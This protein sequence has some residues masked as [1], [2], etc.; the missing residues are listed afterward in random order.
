MI[1]LES[2]LIPAIESDSDKFITGEYIPEMAK[3]IF[4][5]FKPALPSFNWEYVNFRYCIEDRS[6]TFSFYAKNES[7]IKL[8][9][10]C[11]D[12]DKIALGRA[13]KK[14]SDII[15]SYHDRLNKDNKWTNVY[16]KYEKDG[17]FST[18]FSYTAL[19]NQLIPANEAWDTE[20]EISPDVKEVF[21]KL[22]VF[23]RSD[24]LSYSRL[25][26]LI[27]YS[28][29]LEKLTS[30][31]LKKI[32]ACFYDEK[33]AV[34]YFCYDA[35]KEEIYQI[36]K[37]KPIPI[38]AHGNGDHYCLT[39]SLA[40]KEYI[41]DVDPHFDSKYAQDYS[42]FNSWYNGFYKKIQ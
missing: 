33:I 28:D 18:K 40:I 2:Y 3:K 10:F 6:S 32:H 39:S 24:K 35:T 23:S 15:K 29:N 36:R 22:N 21:Q 37:Y 42:S 30:A 26:D 41:H 31:D 13:T 9:D 19:E 17:R 4:D 27:E 7:T 1:N 8:M 5:T 12:S 11:K 14:I 38:Y 34:D 25:S 16:I 20:K